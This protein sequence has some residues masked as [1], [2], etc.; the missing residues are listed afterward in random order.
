MFTV[1]NSDVQLKQLVEDCYP[2]VC[3]INVIT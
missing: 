2:L 3:L 1:Q